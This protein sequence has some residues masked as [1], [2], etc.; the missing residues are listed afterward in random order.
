M[1]VLDHF[2]EYEAAVGV[3]SHQDAPLGDLDIE[4]RLEQPAH[5]LRPRFATTDSQE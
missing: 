4:F 1:L 2:V 5:G 3:Q